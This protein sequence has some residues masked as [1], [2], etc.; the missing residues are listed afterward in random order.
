MKK[1]KIS[2][3]EFEKAFEIARE[4]TESAE[5][6][7]KK[8]LYRD[9]IS[10]SYYALFDVVSALLAEK[11]QIAKTHAGLISLFGKYYIKTNII[12]KKYGQWLTQLAEERQ[13]ADYER[14]AKFTQ[15]DAKKA[16][17]EVK[18]FLKEIQ[19]ISH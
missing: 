2:S 15:R 11:G 4:R 6:L 10:R 13:K 17:S 16:I 8:K 19:K 14:L 1:I 12:P 9:S 3:K 7:L 18:E 5:V